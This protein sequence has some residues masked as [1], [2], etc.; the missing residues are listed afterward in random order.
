MMIASKKGI[1]FSS[2]YDKYAIYLPS[3]QKNYARLPCTNPSSVRDGQL[4]G[5]LKLDDF[6]YLTGESTLWNS[7]YALY[8]AGL[9]NSSFIETP[10]IISTRDPHNTVVIG[11]SGGYQIA[12]S[13]FAA[14]KNWQGLKPDAFCKKWVN[15]LALKAQFLRWLDVYCDYAMTLD[16]PI[17][18]RSVRGSLL[19]NCSVQ[20]LIDL[21]VENLRYFAANTGRD[22]GSKAK[23][24]NVLQDIG[25]QSGDAWYNAVTPFRFTKGWAL[26]SDTK[27][28]L[29]SIIKWLRRLLDDKLLDD[30]E[31]IHVLGL[32]SATMAVNLTAI[33]NALRTATG[34][35]KL[36]I[37]FD[38]SS[39]F[40]S[41][42]K[43]REY[44]DV[45]QLTADIA[46][47]RIPTHNLVQSPKHV[48][49]TSRTYL[50][51]NNGSPVLQRVSLEELHVEKGPMSQTFL[52]EFGEQLMA[53]HN[54][55]VYH[56]TFTDACDLV[57]DAQLRN[58]NRIPKQ[59]QEGLD[60]ISAAFG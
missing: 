3:L 56:R 52:D 39:P 27:K 1:D 15:D 25:D 8:S 14:A 44:C 36:K 23:Y 34:N 41:F 17:W 55:Y 45:P 57:F 54:Q 26:G 21:S 50:L 2:K 43:F 13:S 9:F 10:D 18:A 28:D 29:D 53:N 48:N 16:M 59:V 38:S 31:W 49:S 35:T 42:G 22:T 19:K 37:S 51:P 47:W 32:S 40:Q 58:E 6:N 11:D 4:P 12:K 20:Q 5:N 24:L 7:K 46:T 60:K 30:T 33:Q